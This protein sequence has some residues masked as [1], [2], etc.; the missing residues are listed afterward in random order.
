MPGTELERSVAGGRHGDITGGPLHRHIAGERYRAIGRRIHRLGALDRNRLRE[1]RADGW[2]G[3]ATGEVN[4]LHHGDRNRRR[5]RRCAGLH[6]GCLQASPRGRLSGY[7]ALRDVEVALIGTRRLRGW[8]RGGLGAV[9][10]F[11]LRTRTIVLIC[12]LI[13]IYGIR[14]ASPLATRVFELGLGGEPSERS[15]NHIFE[16]AEERALSGDLATG[17]TRRATASMAGARVP[18]RGGHW[19]GDRRGWGI[20]DKP[21]RGTRESCGEGAQAP[22]GP[23]AAPSHVSVTG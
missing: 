16:G 12:V 21:L 4:V 2:R 6:C 19:T 10:P 20:E 22:T 23:A 7:K 5:E 11:A 14:D 15:S 1:R 9:H 3:R 13:A 17:G 18:R 8:A